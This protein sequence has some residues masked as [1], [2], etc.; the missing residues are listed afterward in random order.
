MPKL[1]LQPVLAM[2]DIVRSLGADEVIDYKKQEFEE[3]L[4]D[5][6]L[7]TGNR[8]GKCNRKITSDSEAK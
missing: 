6:D 4:K 3:V 8:K 2:V 1:E 5:Y 7:P